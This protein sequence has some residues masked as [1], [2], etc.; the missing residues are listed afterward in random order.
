[1]PPKQDDLFIDS[2]SDISIPDDSEF[3]QK[4]DKGKGKANEKRKKG[5]S[6]RKPK[7][8]QAYTWEASYTRSWETVREDEAGSLQHAV[9]DYV[10]RGRRKRHRVL[11]MFYLNGF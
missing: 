9:E 3:G 5:E 6:K 2:D 8:V 1:M 7:D 11:F 10:A 4:K